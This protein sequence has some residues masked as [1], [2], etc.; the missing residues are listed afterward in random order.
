MTFCGLSTIRTG[1]VENWARMI[2]ICIHNIPTLFGTHFLSF[3]IRTTENISV[4]FWRL[5][6][7]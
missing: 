7:A 3:L 1:K 5:F 6:P 2:G 4:E